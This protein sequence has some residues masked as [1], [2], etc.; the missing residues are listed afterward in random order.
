MTAYARILNTGRVTDT[1]LLTAPHGPDAS[2]QH[3]KME[4]V[5]D[6][7]ESKHAEYEAE[8]IDLETPTEEPVEATA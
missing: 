2:A 5:A 6:G 8:P 7:S 1:V 3:R 4:L